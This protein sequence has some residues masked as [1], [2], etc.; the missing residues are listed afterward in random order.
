MLTPRFG[1]RS[2][3]GSLRN[4]VNFSDSTE[5]RTIKYKAIK[6]P[7]HPLNIH[8]ASTF[9]SYKTGVITLSTQDCDPHNR[10]LAVALVGY[11]YDPILQ[12]NYW[13][14]KISWGTNWEEGGC[15]RIARETKVCGIA[16]AACEGII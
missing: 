5:K 10:D 3:P 15:G 6:L 4:V 8:D 14:V 7:G 12:L 2:Q 13:K 11:G 9:Q 16:S 1:R